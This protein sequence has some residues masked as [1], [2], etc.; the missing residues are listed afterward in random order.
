MSEDV[1]LTKSGFEK[2]RVE[3]AE[4]KGPKRQAM[5]EAIREARSH[6]DLKENAAYHEAKLNQAR[7]EGR[8]ADLERVLDIA[9]IV[10]RPESAEETAHL[11][12]RVSLFDFKWEEELVVE[13]VGS[14]EAD[15]SNG[16]VSIDS[17]MGSAL[18][19]RS[20]DEEIEVDAPAGI[21]K[22]RIDKIETP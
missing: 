18:V 22:Y 15:P 7:L 14:F 12:S 11:G 3:L 19:G 4:L 16:L 1:F 5:S 9:E 17:P 6:G 10:E 21:Q 2:L 8:I 20:E 13:L